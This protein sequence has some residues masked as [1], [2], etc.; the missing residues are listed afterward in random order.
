M[1]IWASGFG[2]K[3]EI[4]NRVIVTDQGYVICSEEA[5][6]LEDKRV[7]KKFIGLFFI[8][9]HVTLHGLSKVKAILKE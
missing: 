2:Q 6:K 8:P 4:T 7:G 1:Y 9:L 3:T 5:V